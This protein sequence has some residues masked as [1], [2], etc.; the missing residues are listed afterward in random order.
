MNDE[1]LSISGGEEIRKGAW[2]SEEDSIL[3]DYIATHG[4]GRWSSLARDS[5]M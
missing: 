5:G 1:I 2:S 3:I 4:E